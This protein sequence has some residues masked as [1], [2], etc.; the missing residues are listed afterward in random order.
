MTEVGAGGQAK[1]GAGIARGREKGR[2]CRFD[3]CKVQ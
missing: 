1:V 2:E 3:A